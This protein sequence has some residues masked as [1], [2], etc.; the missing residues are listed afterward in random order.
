[1]HPAAAFEDGR[2]PGQ[3]RRL[4]PR[5]R[6]LKDHAAVEVSKQTSGQLDAFGLGCPLLLPRVC[7]EIGMNP[8][9]LIGVD[10]LQPIHDVGDLGERAPPPA[11]GWRQRAELDDVLGLKD[12][13]EKVDALGER[14]HCYS[15][16]G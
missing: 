8:L 1:M 2:G 4:D 5:V 6:L 3:A 7:P 13:A 12:R 11:C 9:L 10:P 15:M 16:C 14:V